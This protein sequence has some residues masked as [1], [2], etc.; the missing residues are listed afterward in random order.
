MEP[1]FQTSFIPKKPMIEERAVAPR[2]IGFLTII[3]LFLLITLII[4]SV[5]LYFY[6]GVV[7]GNITEMSDYLK[8]AQSRYEPAKIKELQVLDRRLKAANEILSSHISVT[9]IFELL[10]KVT[11]KTVRY[12]KFSY[13]IGTEKDKN[14]LVKLSGTA[15]GYRSIALQSDIFTEN[16]QIIDPLF[17]NLVL[18]EKGNVMF[19]LEFSVDPSLIDYKQMILTESDDE[20]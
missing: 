4:V 1:N 14:V 8:T 7:S 17:S 9:P 2:P 5:G 12:T 20:N 6:K 3:S 16:K 15:V 10:Q 13:S 18:D 19:E 11:M